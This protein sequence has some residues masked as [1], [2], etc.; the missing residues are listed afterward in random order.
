M[1]DKA[2]IRIPFHPLY[3]QKLSVNNGAMINAREYPNEIPLH[4]EVVYIDGTP[5]YREER[6]QKWDS[7]S[8]SLSS[9]AVG[10]FPEGN[11]FNPWPCVCIKAS[12]S[13][14]LQGHNVF[15]SEN[16]RP[17]IMQML[18]SLE[19]AF[20]KVCK[21]LD[22]E[23]AEL[24][25]VDTT[26]STFI[27]S[28]YTR[29]KILGLFDTLVHSSVKRDRHTGYLLLHANSDRRRLK[30]YDKAAEVL[31]DLEKAKRRG[32]TTRY[33]ILSDERLQEFAA[34]RL[35]FEATTGFRAMEEEGIPTNLFEF[36]KFHDW[37][38]QCHKQ[39]LSQY[40]WQKAFNKLFSQ[41]EGHT[42]KN[43]DDEKIKLKIDAKYI[44]IKDNGRICKRR[45]NGIFNTYRQI[46]AEGY[47]AL[48]KENSS[49]FYRNVNFMV[50]AGISRA[51]L[52]S[53]DPNKP[54]DNIV[55][56]IK[57]I[58]IDFSNQR[59]SWYVEPE[60]NFSI[61]RQLKLTA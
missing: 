8:S 33:E 20:P 61:E 40:L 6:T 22:F 2:D 39:P 41:I 31:H 27:Q 59:P 32:E 56:M 15:G 47:D 35:R 25:Y 44:T 52:K 23:R 37:F 30:I 14:I 1:Y 58:E 46:K 12:P 54:N 57:L 43:V 53:L 45:A 10:F 28:N 26:Y 17:G 60:A 19:L 49:T 34:G 3:V 16:I 55:P 7:I 51:F 11:G 42:M 13:K 24:R 18:G 21:H 9:I 38:Y 29:S 4:C 36:L 48:A 5:T 50:D